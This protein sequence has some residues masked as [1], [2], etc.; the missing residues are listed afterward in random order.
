MP[1]PHARNWAA[2]FAV[3]VIAA[4]GHPAAAQEAAPSQPPLARAVK[5]SQPP[6]VDGNIAD[7]PAW[8]AATPVTDFWQTSPDAGL[9]ASERTEVRIVAT[10]R[11]TTATASGSCSTRIAI[12]RTGSC[13]RPTPRRSSTTVR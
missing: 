5:V 3:C 12:D 2:S 11:S 6:V 7:D 1:R 10:R 13:S 8:Q 4:C 9:P